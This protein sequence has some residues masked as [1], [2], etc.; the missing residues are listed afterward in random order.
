MGTV[1]AV[2]PD[3]VTMATP[4][5][6][7]YD[8]GYLVPARLCR[9][10]GDECSISAY[11]S[12]LLEA[13]VAFE[14]EEPERLASAPLPVFAD[15]LGLF[16]YVHDFA[17]PR[18][19][20]LERSMSE[21]DSGLALP[22]RTD[23]RGYPI[24]RMAFEGVLLGGRDKLAALKGFFQSVN[25]RAGEFWVEINE[26]LLRLSRPI[27]KGTTIM[28]VSDAAYGVLSSGLRS[29]RKLSILTRKGRY[30]NEVTSFAE[31]AEGDLTLTMANAWTVDLEPGDVDRIGFLIKAR[32]DQDELEIEHVADDLARVS[33]WIRGLPN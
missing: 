2:A 23:R 6:G 12:E 15:G 20:F 13:E 24:D 28:R 31:T 8:W 25:A 29:R 27:T 10:A 32:L 21:H 19:R 17:S 5:G 22:S 11:T 9:L 3:S 18:E 26:A 16:P 1:A 7:S 14:A 4:A 30:L 33:L